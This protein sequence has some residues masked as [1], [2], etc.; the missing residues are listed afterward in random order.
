[1]KHPPYQ[2]TDVPIF[3]LHT[4][5]VWSQEEHRNMGAWTF[6]QP[7]FEN[8]IGKKVRCNPLFQS[9]PCPTLH[10]KT[11]LI[12]LKNRNFPHSLSTADAQRQRLLPRALAKCINGKLMRL[13]KRHL[14]FSKLL[15]TAPPHTTHCHAKYSSSIKVPK[16]RTAGRGKGKRRGQ[17]VACGATK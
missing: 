7:R 9:L 4:A 1:M 15:P 5:Y 10:G 6:V 14:M 17:G 16:K 8:L 13:Y 2:P 11:C 12:P 3:I